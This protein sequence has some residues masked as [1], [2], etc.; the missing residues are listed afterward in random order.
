MPAHDVTVTGSYTIDEPIIRV[1]DVVYQYDEQSQGYQI[2]AVVQDEDVKE[3]TVPQ[4]VNGHPVVGV[5]EGAFA[6][7]TDLTT[8]KYNKPNK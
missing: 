7:K 1:D 8:N 4:E 6:G 3:V 5:A 2:S